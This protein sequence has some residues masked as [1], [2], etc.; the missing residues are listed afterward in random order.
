MA[1]YSDADA[2]NQRQPAVSAQSKGWENIGS[3]RDRRKENTM[4]P[5]PWVGETLKTEKK[6]AKPAKMTIYR[7]EV[8]SELVSIPPFNSKYLR[9]QD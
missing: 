3:L 5:R 8:S 9:P 7:D 4:E 1:I 2:S 6:V